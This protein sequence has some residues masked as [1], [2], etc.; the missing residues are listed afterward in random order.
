M[1]ELGWL[2]GDKAAA[3]IDPVVAFLSNEGLHLDV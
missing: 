2:V 3:M 1:A